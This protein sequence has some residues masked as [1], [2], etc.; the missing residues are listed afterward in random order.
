MV[1]GATEA[2]GR[3]PRRTANEP[4]LEVRNWGED[5][6]WHPLAIVDAHS[7]ADV[8]AIVSDRE[9]YPAP[10][11][12]LGSRHST[13]PAAEAN[14]GTTVRMRG[15][16]RILEVGETTVRAEAGALYIDV[17]KEL[18][19]RNLQFHVNVELG[20]LTI[21]SAACCATKEAS[22]PGEYAQVSSYCVAMTVVTADGSVLEIT[23]TATRS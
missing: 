18:Q 2:V 22:L 20:N 17:A 21:G 11:R 19:R 1:A 3:E 23:R 5:I 9:R 6:V 4:R 15:M 14:G 8:V 16:D 13:T 10:V 12:A 7:V